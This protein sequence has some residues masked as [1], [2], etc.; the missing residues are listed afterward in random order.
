M[1]TKELKTF[2]KEHLVPSKL[3]KI[4]G[5]HDGRVCMTKNKDFWE[6]YFLDHK[7]K[8][9]LMRYTDENS[10]CQS[11]KE[12]LRKLMESIYEITW[13]PIRA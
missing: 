13:K 7:E 2:F 1:T 6:V 9:G 10:A 5:E 8:I 3:Y 11:M 4:G 12:E